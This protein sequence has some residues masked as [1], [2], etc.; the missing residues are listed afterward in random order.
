[1]LFTEES[2]INIHYKTPTSKL[3]KMNTLNDFE[4]NRIKKLYR[5]EFE[6]RLQRSR[7]TRVRGDGDIVCD[8]DDRKRSLSAPRSSQR[9]EASLPAHGNSLRN[10][11]Y[12]SE[13]AWRRAESQ[14]AEHL[15]EAPEVSGRTLSPF[16]D[17]H[18][19]E[20][21]FSAKTSA[22][23]EAERRRWRGAARF[24]RALFDFQAK[25]GRELSLCRGDLV[26]LLEFLDHTWARVE[27]CQSG[28]QGL[29]PLNYID[30]SVGCAVAK[31]DIRGQ[32]RVIREGKPNSSVPLLP[33]SK[34]EPITLI[35]RLSGF[36]YE[37]SNT[38]RISGLV[39]SKDVEIIKQ[40]VLRDDGSHNHQEE[41]WRVQS[42]RFPTARPADED[43]C[44]EDAI[45]ILESGEQVLARKPRQPIERTR[46]ASKSD[47]R[48][49]C[50]A[51]Q[52]FDD[53]GWLTAP[54][55]TQFR[56]ETQL[57]EQ[58][59]KQAA[60]AMRTSAANP[61]RSSSSPYISTTTETTKRVVEER[62]SFE[63]S[64]Q[65]TNRKLVY[66]GGEMAPAQLFQV[67]HPYKPQ[68]TDEIELIVGDVLSVVHKCDDGWFIGTSS[69]SGKCGTFP[70]NFVEQL[71]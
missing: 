28:L 42:A 36:W 55:Q 29:V 69:A 12:S 44:A 59:A 61:R 71:N 54:R 68:K 34:G 45:Y 20:R 23:S 51:S 31:R 39:W 50:C 41:A 17:P 35:R 63:E 47:P 27:D 49:L 38:R 11:R 48:C 30:V 53:A 67:K 66:A 1:M 62:E 65:Q 10:G 33:M 60:I 16:V 8:T 2:P 5:D 21:A 26:E 25:S 43:D 3:L 64:R 9:V 22:V 57:R 14:S 18:R 13:T 70:G 46:A 6:S 24:G 32:E 7:S 15:F 4:L 40:P 56:Y 52:Q 19:Y 58:P 37:A